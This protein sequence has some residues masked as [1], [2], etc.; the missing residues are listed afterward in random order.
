MK[1]R[2]I[3][4]MTE[5]EQPCIYL[6]YKRDYKG[7]WKKFFEEDDKVVYVGQSKR[8]LERIFEHKDKQF[9]YIEIIPCQKS[10]LNELEQKYI[11]FYRP[12]YN[13]MLIDRE[14]GARGSYH[15]SCF[16]CKYAGKMKTYDTEEKQGTFVYC[17]KDK[18]EHHY[19]GWC[20]K[21]TYNHV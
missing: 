15:N 9:D 14:K 12:I 13:T 2:L 3:Y 21:Q 18:R 17:S 5:I 19:F 6:L 16:N 4:N 1:K 8:G 7:E 10:K 20:E 11:E